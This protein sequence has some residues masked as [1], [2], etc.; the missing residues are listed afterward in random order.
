MSFGLPCTTSSPSLAR[1]KHM[2]WEYPTSTATATWLACHLLN[3]LSI[4]SHIYKKNNTVNKNVKN[5]L[6]YN[7]YKGVQHG[8]LIISKK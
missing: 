2:S 6:I 1:Y 8:L 5:I 7:S 4:P 3:S